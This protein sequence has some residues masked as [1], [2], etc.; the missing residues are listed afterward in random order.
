MSPLKIPITMHP[1]QQQ[2][3]L[4]WS[5]HHPISFYSQ[6]LFDHGFMI[7]KLEEWTSDKQSVGGKTATMEN[8][9]R[10]E[11]PLFMAIKA[12]KK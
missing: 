5:F 2:S 4:T 10:S 3:A 8:R 7:E 12:I 6:I 11:F 1:G 9:G